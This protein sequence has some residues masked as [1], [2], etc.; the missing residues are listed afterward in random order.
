M[1]VRIVYYSQS[2]SSVFY[3]QTPQNIVPTLLASTRMKQRGF[4]EEKET[5]LSA[6]VPM[7]G[8]VLPP[9]T[10]PPSQKKKT[11]QL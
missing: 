7:S 11:P 3:S 4:G 10:A 2:N 9:H 8:W 5:H 6:L 1:R